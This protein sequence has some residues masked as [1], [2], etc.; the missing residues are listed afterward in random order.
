MQMILGMPVAVLHVLAEQGSVKPLLVFRMIKIY[1]SKITMY[2]VCVKRG[3]SKVL[4][5]LDFFFWKTNCKLWVHK[6]R[7]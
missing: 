7:Y 5:L 1:D 6:S 4:I 3:I 2:T